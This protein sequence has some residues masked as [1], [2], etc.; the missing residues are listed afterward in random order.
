[1]GQVE[2][3]RTVA[4]SCIFVF[5]IY[6]PIKGTDALVY[7]VW[8]VNEAIS[9]NICSP[10]NRQPIL[11]SDIPDDPK[12]LIAAHYLIDCPLP[13]NDWFAFVGLRSRYETVGI[14]GDNWPLCFRFCH[15]LT[16]AVRERR[17]VLRSD[18]RPRINDKGRT[19]AAVF[20]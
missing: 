15:E 6:A 18:N 17:V 12:I 9:R 7:G 16:E 20:N 8:H 3:T 19:F 11:I 10:N 4:L 13:E 2:W 5:F 1:G 14:S